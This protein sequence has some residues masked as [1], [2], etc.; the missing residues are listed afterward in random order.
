MLL[1]ENGEATAVVTSDLGGC[2]RGD[3]ALGKGESDFPV[4]KDGKGDPRADDL[5]DTDLWFSNA[6]EKLPTVL[7][8]DDFSLTSLAGELGEFIE[9]RGDMDRWVTKPDFGE[10][11]FWWFTFPD[12]G[13]A[14][15]WFNKRIGDADLWL[16]KVLGEHDRWARKCFGDC[17]LDSV[18]CRADNAEN[19]VLGD[20]DRRSA[21]CDVDCAESWDN[22]G[23]T[24]WSAG[25]ELAR[26]VVEDSDVEG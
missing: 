20:W 13:E 10:G 6:D 11:G 12:L 24:G 1:I 23:N 2:N 14:G 7:G 18:F 17:D 9:S 25:Y 5:G 26:L 3:G 4:Y 19:G 21:L 15:F 16:R 8:E 22:A